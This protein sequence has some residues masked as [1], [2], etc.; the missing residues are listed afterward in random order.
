MYT[1]V[2]I[3]HCTPTGQLNYL[4]LLLFLSCMCRLFFS[5]SLIKQ[6]AHILS[7]SASEIP[8]A[9]PHCDVTAFISNTKLRKH[10]KV[11]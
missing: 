4:R 2:T 11:L 6:E 9:P 8:E 3:Y 5:G 1:F 7:Y 10:R